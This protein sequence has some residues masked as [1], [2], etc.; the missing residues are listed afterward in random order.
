MSD[1]Q[2]ENQEKNTIRI[3]PVTIVAVI[4]ALILIPLVLAGFLSQ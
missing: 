4:A 1:R 2:K 3:D